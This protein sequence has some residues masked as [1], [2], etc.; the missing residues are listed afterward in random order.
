MVFSDSPLK[1]FF[2]VF[3]PIFSLFKFVFIILFLSLFIYLF[4]FCC[5]LHFNFTADNLSKKEFKHKPFIFIKWV[6]FDLVTH[7]YS[8]KN[9]NEFGFTFFVGRQGAG[10]TISM[11]KYLED[12]RN[13]FPDCIIVSNF[14]CKYSDCIMKDWRD[15]LTIRNGDKGVVFA[16]DEIHSEYSSASWKDFPESLLSEISQ[17]RKQK[18]KIIASAQ[19]FMRVAKPLREQAFEIVICKTFL[20]RLTRCV[21]Y[22]AFEYSSVA[23]NQLVIKEHLKPNRKYSFVQDDV[24][25]QSYDTYEKIKRM[26]KIRFIPRCER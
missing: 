7:S 26:E 12:I 1:T 16:I 17:Q 18:V 20:K 3:S 22:D 11:V 21:V 4:I 2:S 23:E 13:R 9:F 10:K 5:L 8:S 6:L 15:L 19:A 24:L 14:Y 25:R